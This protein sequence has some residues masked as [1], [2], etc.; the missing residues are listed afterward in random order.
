[1]SGSGISYNN[2]DV[3][4]CILNTGFFLLLECLINIWIKSVK[5]HQHPITNIRRAL[6]C[7]QVKSK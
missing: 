2:L 5:L 7:L 1:M 3:I 4:S 6:A